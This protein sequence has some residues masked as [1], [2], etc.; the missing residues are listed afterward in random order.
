MH[1]DL[2]L[3]ERYGI[4]LLLQAWNHASIAEWSLLNAAKEELKITKK[5]I[6]DLKI[7]SAP[8]GLI[9]D[10]EKGKEPY[11]FELDERV[12]DMVKEKINILNQKKMVPKD[13]LPLAIKLGIQ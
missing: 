8:T 11:G 3:E 13:L 6:A 12:M 1:Y 4:L 7:Q 5:N 10:A 2:N 9:W